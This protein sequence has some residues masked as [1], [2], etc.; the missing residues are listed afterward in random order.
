[1]MDMT[2]DTALREII[3]RAT[4]RDV[5]ALRYDDSLRRILGIDIVDLVRITVAAE[6]AYHV[7]CDAASLYRV[8]RFGD[9]VAALS[10]GAERERS[11]A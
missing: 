8:D 3:S 6:T 11:A 7:E 4:G 1:M 5:S 2:D 9:L 10:I